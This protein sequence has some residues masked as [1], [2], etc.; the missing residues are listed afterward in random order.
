MHS[1]TT[2]ELLK[3]LALFQQGPISTQAIRSSVAL[4]IS[5]LEEHL[6]QIPAVGLEVNRAVF[7][8]VQTAAFALMHRHEAHCTRLDGA[9]HIQSMVAAYRAPDR[10]R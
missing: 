1:V 4:A 2:N 5:H 8:Q 6:L 3:D 9:T 10:P 7:A